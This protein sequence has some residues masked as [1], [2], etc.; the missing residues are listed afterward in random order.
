MI[1]AAC[2]PKGGVGKTTTAVNVAAVLADSGQSVLLVDLEPDLN[3][4]ISLGVRP[5]D[6]Q[7]AILDVILNAT[8]PSDAVRG[9]NG[10]DNLFLITGSP[11]L[12]SLDHSLR[13]V[14]QPERRLGDALRPLE[15]QFDT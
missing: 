12:A 7:R 5:G 4:S 13:N 15:R 8:R 14:R 1:I 6:T 10:F 2:T 3:A 11:G 9:V